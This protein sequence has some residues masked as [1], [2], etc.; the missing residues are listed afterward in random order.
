[1]FPEKLYELDHGHSSEILVRFLLVSSRWFGN[2]DI[3]GVC[4]E[5]ADLLGARRPKD[6]AIMAETT[7]GMS[8]VR[9]KERSVVITPTNA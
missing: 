9:D 3:T 8:V 7:G 2:K 4:H 6:P 5:W 1:M